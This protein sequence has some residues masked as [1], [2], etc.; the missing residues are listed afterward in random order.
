MELLA[1]IRAMMRRATLVQVFGGGKWAEKVA[2]YITAV[3]F[4]LAF[5][6]DDPA[7]KP[8]QTKSNQVK[9]HLPAA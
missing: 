8:S 4:D 6:K 3:N 5:P 1:P 7:V 9:P 2:D